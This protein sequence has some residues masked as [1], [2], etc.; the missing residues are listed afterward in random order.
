MEGIATSPMAIVAGGVIPVIAAKK[1]Q[2]TT[3]PIAS[4]PPRPPTNLYAISYAAPAIP[5]YR[6]RLPIKRNIGNARMTG[7]HAVE[8]KVVGT[9]IR[10]RGVIR[11]ANIHAEPTK[12]KVTGNPKSRGTKQHTNIKIVISSTLNLAYL[13]KISFV[14]TLGHRF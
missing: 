12:P 10:V 1:V 3:V 6:T 7:C 14:P 2:M 4:P 13:T 11:R 5:E 9:A 8:K